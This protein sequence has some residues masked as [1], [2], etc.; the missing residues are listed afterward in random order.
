[1][2]WD[3]L[4][5]SYLGS[6]AS[7]PSFAPIHCHRRAAA[8]ALPRSSSG[9]PSSTTALPVY[10]ARVEL[11]PLGCRYSRR[12]FDAVPSR[13][14]LRA[15][16]RPAAAPLSPHHSHTTP[17]APATAASSAALGPPVPPHTRAPAPPPVPHW[18]SRT[19]AAHH[20][21]PPQRARVRDLDH[22][23]PDALPAR[24][25]H[26]E[27]PLRPQRREFRIREF[28]I[29]LLRIGFQLFRFV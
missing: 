24:A 11:V 15:A 4:T 27:N 14:Q 8:A 9:R 3:Y 25:Q 23:R 12:Q 16:P 20:R 10:L 29:H 21:R 1:M 26:H 18:Q 7:R 2:A 17:S 19:R 22:L 6:F 5:T 28:R 13:A